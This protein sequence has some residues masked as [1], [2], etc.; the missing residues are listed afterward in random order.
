M[1][2][3]S[4]IWRKGQ[5]Q[6]DEYVDF[7]TDFESDRAQAF[8]QI[9]AD[10]NYAAFVNGELAAFGQYADYPQYKVYDQVEITRWLKKGKNRLAIQVWYY[11]EDTQTYL[12]GKAGLIFQVESE[13]KILAKSGSHVL[14][15]LSPDYHQGYEIKISSQLGFSY[16]YNIRGYDGWNQPEGLLDG[17]EESREEKEISKQLHIRPTKSWSCSPLL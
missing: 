17:F 11:G 12:V 1:E 6:V 16:H 9:A 5:A 8:L 10:S 14:S 4:W 15:R 2:T 13:G 3:A 7:V